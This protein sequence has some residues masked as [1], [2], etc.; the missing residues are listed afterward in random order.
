MTR[1]ELYN[2]IDEAQVPFHEHLWA[3]L[4]V[5]GEVTDE[6]NGIKMQISEIMID[7]PVQLDIVTGENGE[8]VIGSSPPLYYLE[9]GIMPV[10]H[11]ISCRIVAE[12]TEKQKAD[13]S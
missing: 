7:S 10:F 13:E 4:E 9:T 12:R 5:D 6:E 8:M 11:N 3:M 2:G 1:E